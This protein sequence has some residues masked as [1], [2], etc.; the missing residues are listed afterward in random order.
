MRCYT[1]MELWHG[2]LGPGLIVSSGTLGSGL[3]VSS[4]TLGPGPVVP[5]Q[6]KIACTMVARYHRFPILR[7]YFLL[8]FDYYDQNDRRNFTKLW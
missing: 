7:P 5:L 8:K 3:I 4:G 6:V 2:T 1:N